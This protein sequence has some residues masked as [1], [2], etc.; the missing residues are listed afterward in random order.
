MFAKHGKYEMDIG[1]QHF[2]ILTMCPAEARKDILR[3]YLLSKYPTHL[4]LK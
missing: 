4:E 1:D 2:V 3:E